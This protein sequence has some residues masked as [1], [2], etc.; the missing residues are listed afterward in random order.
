MKKNIGVSPNN[1]ICRMNGKKMF[2]ID[3]FYQNKHNHQLFLR[4]FSQVFEN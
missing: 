1:K 4:I 3:L 2:K